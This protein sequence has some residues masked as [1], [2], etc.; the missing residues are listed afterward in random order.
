MALDV[1]IR[2]T[3]L[4]YPEPSHEFPL[5]EKSLEAVQLRRLFLGLAWVGSGERGSSKAASVGDDRR[6]FCFAAVRVLR[7]TIRR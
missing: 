2:T 5:S 7:I 4:C 6:W 1:D 3:Y